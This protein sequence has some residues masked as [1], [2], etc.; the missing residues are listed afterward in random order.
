MMVLVTCLFALR[1]IPC[2][3]QALL[4]VIRVSQREGETWVFCFLSVSGSNSSSVSSSQTPPLGDPS[5][6]LPRQACLN[7]AV[8]RLP[9]PLGSENTTSC[10]PPPIC[11]EKPHYFLITYLAWP[12]WKKNKKE[13]TNNYEKKNFELPEI[14][15]SSNNHNQHINCFLP[16]FFCYKYI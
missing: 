3:F 6:S 8:S 13:K 15:L 16:V 10:L 1:P 11:S 12:L 2:P 4:C 14:P 5:C 9:Q 7:P